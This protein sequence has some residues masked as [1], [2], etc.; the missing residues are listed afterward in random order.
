[1]ANQTYTFQFPTIDIGGK[2]VPT[3]STTEVSQACR[4]LVGEV[5]NATGSGITIHITDAAGSPGP[6]DI[7]PSQ[8][9]PANGGS[10]SWNFGDV[11]LYA[12]GGIIWQA[13]GAGLYGRFTVRP[14]L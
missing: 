11:G 14:I 3:G 7:I 13:G 8:T 1:M 12:A 5:T 10:V 4:M 2:A 9:V 6:Y